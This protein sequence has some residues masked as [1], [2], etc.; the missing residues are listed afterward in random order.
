MGGQYTHASVWVIIAE[1]MLKFGDKAVNFYNMINP[2]EHSKTK[3]SAN[4]YKV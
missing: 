1:A 3:E 2:I 4:K